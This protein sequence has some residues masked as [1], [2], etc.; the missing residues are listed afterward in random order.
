MLNGKLQSELFYCN[1]LGVSDHDEQDIINFTIRDENGSGLLRYIRYL[2]F[3]E[4]DAGTMRTYIVRDNRSSEMVGYFSLKAGLISHNER[5]ILVVDEE[6]GE[7]VIDEETGE[8]KTRRVF[9][10]LPGVELAN[11]AVNQ[12]YID[13]LQT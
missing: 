8:I 9:D 2:A 4:E 7:A 13:N 10:T 3:P 1:H 12:R 6:T 5:D 11:F